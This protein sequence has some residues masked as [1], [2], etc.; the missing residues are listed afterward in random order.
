MNL[1]FCVNYAHFRKSG[2]ILC[3]LDLKAKVYWLIS[4]YQQTHLL[5]IGKSNIHIG[6]TL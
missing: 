6:A 3:F 1:N 2:Q 4:A 5:V